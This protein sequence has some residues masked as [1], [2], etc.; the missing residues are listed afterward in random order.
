MLDGVCET[1]SETLGRLH[2]PWIARA[3]GYCYIGRQ[4]TEMQYVLDLVRDCSQEVTDM[5]YLESLFL[6]GFFRSSEPCDQVVLL[7]IGGTLFHVRRIVA[8]R[9]QYLDSFLRW[10]MSIAADDMSRADTEP[11]IDLSGILIDRNPD[12]FQTLLTF[13]EIYGETPHNLQKIQTEASFFGVNCDPRLCF[14]CR[15][16]YQTD[17]E[18]MPLCAYEHKVCSTCFCEEC[19]SVCLQPFVNTE[20]MNEADVSQSNDS[21]LMFPQSSE[22]NG[23]V[24][25]IAKG[26][27]DMH[28][29][30]PYNLQN[31]IHKTSRKRVTSSTFTYDTQCF[32]KNEG[33][34]IWE[35]Q[36]R[37]N[38]DMLGDSWLYV[39]LDISQHDL[40]RDLWGL[41]RMVDL[42]Q[43]SIGGGVVEDITYAVLYGLTRIG[44]Q[45]EPVIEPISDTKTRLVFPL[46]CFWWK[47]MATKLRL[48]GL[49]YHDVKVTLKLSG[50]IAIDVKLVTTSWFLDTAER[51]SVAQNAVEELVVLHN[52]I[53]FDINITEERDPMHCQNLSGV[54]NHAVKDMLLVVRPKR[55]LNNT[56]NTGPVRLINFELNGTVHLS[57]DGLFSR[58][59]LAKHLY[60]T[61]VP[62]DEF[63]YFIPFD[64]RVRRRDFADSIIANST[65][66]FSRI[67]KL[68]LR[69]VLLPGE[70]D[71]YLI[72]R[73]INIMRYVG[74]MAA[75]AFW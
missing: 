48:V 60:N 57:L 33:R 64:T 19:C 49:R 25:L 58:K 70:Y 65:I 74:G 21:L 75:K 27:Q 28:I 42:L 24:A 72:A 61:D 26:S 5:R 55:H 31:S 10:Q 47:M 7:N 44:E 69:L 38:C 34:G 35:L 20:K 46:S 8:N 14:L 4:K 23:L 67:E 15:K 71:C 45:A 9:I 39:D 63:I 30:D 36:L 6:F 51:R 53:S 52:S 43:I 40:P 37:K 13:V 62:A 54:F 3:D 59:I 41:C 2:L 29:T 18:A 1:S 68:E 50:P 73:H 56:G 17:D 32:E 16:Q 22:T 12:K 11:L 66:N